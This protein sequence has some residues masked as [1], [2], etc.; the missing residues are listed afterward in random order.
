MLG[1]LDPRH[2]QRRPRMPAGGGAGPGDTNPIPDPLPNGYPFDPPAHDQIAQLNLSV[3]EA[4]VHMAADVFV[5]AIGRSEKTPIWPSN[6]AAGRRARAGAARRARLRPAQKTW[7]NVALSRSR[8]ATSILIQTVRASW[9]CTSRAAPRCPSSLQIHAGH[10][11]AAPNTRLVRVVERVDGKLVGG[12][13]YLVVNRSHHE[14]DAPNSHERDS[15]TGTHPA[16]RD[17]ARHQHHAA[18][19][20]LR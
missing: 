19:R 13:S 20:H 3:L 12:V 15:A 16:V 8:A 5:N 11:A 14:Q 17:R 10:L 2:R 18:G 6:S 4:D 7:S 1:A 9:K